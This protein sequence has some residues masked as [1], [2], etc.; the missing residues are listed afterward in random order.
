LQ[1]T[2]SSVAALALA[3]AAERQYRWAD[4][5][6]IVH[7]SDDFTRMAV[8]AFPELA[9][10]FGEWHDLLH[11]KM[12]S[13]SHIAQAAKGA[14]DWDKY[15][16]CMQLAD[17]LVRDPAPDM[18]NALNVSFLEHLDFEGPRGSKAWQCLS[19]RLQRAW[20]EMQRYLE[21]VHGA[22]K[23]RPRR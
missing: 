8:A 15:T 3:P 2:D 9:E 19:P 21:G 10:E 4:S 5:D 1:L 18:E 17:E 16:R 7:T 14:G 20:E 6:S 12:G 11:L 13:F 23:K 22:S